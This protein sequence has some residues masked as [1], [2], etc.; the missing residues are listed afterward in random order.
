[1]K[2]GIIIIYHATQRKERKKGEEK[3]EEIREC[4]GEKIS[5]YQTIK[6]KENEREKWTAGLGVE[7]RRKDR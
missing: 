3:K 7:G 5:K 2:V 6:R 1:M 4:K